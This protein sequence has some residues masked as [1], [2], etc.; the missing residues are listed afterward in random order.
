MKRKPNLPSTSLEANR[1]AVPEMREA[2]HAKIIEAL[3]ELRSANYEIIA[4]K[5]GMD[6]HQIG[7]RLSELESTGVVYKPGIKTKTSSGREA[8]NYALTCE[9][10]LSPTEEADVIIKHAT[11]LTSKKKV[12]FYAKK[13]TST[14][15]QKNPLF[16]L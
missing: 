6:R 5:L 16:D 11:E 15:T 14:Q 12:T 8:F 3:K 4:K 9:P 7:R 10:K 2:H 1:R 13:Q